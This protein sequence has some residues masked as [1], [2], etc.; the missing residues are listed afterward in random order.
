MMKTSDEWLMIAGG[1]GT[2]ALLFAVWQKAHRT[3]SGYASPTGPTT[4]NI[5]SNPSG[6]SV[7]GSFPEQ[8]FN[9]PVENISIGGTT[10]G[11]AQY[12][13]G[14]NLF[15]YFGYAVQSSGLQ[16]VYQ[17]I[18]N[19]MA[20][21]AQYQQGQNVVNQNYNTQN[22]GLFTGAPLYGGGSGLIGQV[23]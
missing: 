6:G 11:G 4:V 22:T 21:N 16:Q 7:P 14:N 2:I 9:P 18:N 10:F 15:P 1:V 12:S 20:N 5:A 23:G 13:F 3:S 17:T 8:I 19:L